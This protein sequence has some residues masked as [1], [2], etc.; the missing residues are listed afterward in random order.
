MGILLKGSVG[1][2]LVVIFCFFVLLVDTLSDSILLSLRRK[3]L[4]L[5]LGY[6]M[7]FV[8]RLS[9]IIS[10]IVAAGRSFVDID[11]ARKIVG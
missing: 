3:L 11:Y 1:L 10:A 9:A 5:V 6:G 7:D 2:A 4:I 8:E